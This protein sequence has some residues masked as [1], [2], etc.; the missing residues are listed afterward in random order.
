MKWITHG[1]T[2]KR[3]EELFQM[4]S[5]MKEDTETT[6]VENKKILTLLDSPFAYTNNF[7]SGSAQS[8]N[9]SSV[10]HHDLQ[11][12][13]S[14]NF[15]DLITFMIFRLKLNRFI[16]DDRKSFNQH[17]LKVS[18]F[19]QIVDRWVDNVQDIFRWN[20]FW[21]ESFCWQQKIFLEGNQNK[22]E[23]VKVKETR[24]NQKTKQQKPKCVLLRT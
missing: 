15:L 22:D 8:I 24:I 14:I 21:F 1:G 18:L 7:F 16:Y 17:Q 12:H 23:R 10:F 11:L 19:A 9:F 2:T 4:I 20:K 6:N 5:R 3:C 13:S